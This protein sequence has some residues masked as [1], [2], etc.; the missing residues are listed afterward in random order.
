M[1]A[2]RTEKAPSGAVIAVAAVIAWYATMIADLA[3][4]VLK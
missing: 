2:P 4:Q 3:I 1:S